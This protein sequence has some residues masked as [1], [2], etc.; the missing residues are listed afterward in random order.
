MGCCS[1]G[2]AV[3]QPSDEAV[4][5]MLKEAANRR[6]PCP[7]N[8]DIIEMIGWKSISSASAC[9]QRLEREGLIMVRRFSKSRIV[10]I[11]ES[12][13]ETSPFPHGR[14][15]KHERP[16]KAPPA[17]PPRDPCPKCGVRS[18]LHADWGCGR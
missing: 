9:L 3:M 15:V 7:S 16:I 18:D 5:G 12:G 1:C 4:Y 8:L 11:T 6:A 17:Q 2:G 10:A 14:E 13:V